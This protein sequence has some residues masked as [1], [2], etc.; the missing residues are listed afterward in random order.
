[1][2]LLSVGDMCGAE[3]SA[4]EWLRGREGVR[5]LKKKRGLTAML[6]TD[7]KLGTW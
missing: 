2:P 4:G 6:F 1:V 5:V 3:G 7:L